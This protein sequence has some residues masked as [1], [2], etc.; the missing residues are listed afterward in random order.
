MTPILNEV[1]A[2][3]IPVKNI[4]AAKEWYCELLGLEA[5]GDIIAGHLFIVPMNG[6]GLVLDSKIYTEEN[7]YQTPPFHFDTK[8]IHAAFSYMK[9]KEIEL[10]T[11]IENG[12]WFNFK[13]PDGNVLMVCE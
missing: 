13:D 7:V 3:F 12:H 1:G 9:A 5:E 11:D 4:E 6:T 10:I 8:D 2:V